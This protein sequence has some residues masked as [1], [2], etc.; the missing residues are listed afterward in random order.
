M[1][2]AKQLIL[3]PTSRNFLFYWEYFI[4]RGKR[5]YHATFC[6]ILLLRLLPIK[7]LSVD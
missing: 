3:I 5:K 6:A 2:L 7:L 4:D 1:R